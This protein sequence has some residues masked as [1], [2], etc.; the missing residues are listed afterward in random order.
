[1]ARDF[2]AKN[3]IGSFEEIKKKCYEVLKEIG[4]DWEQ[5]KNMGYPLMILDKK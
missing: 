3:I 4:A 2:E 1:M 5:T